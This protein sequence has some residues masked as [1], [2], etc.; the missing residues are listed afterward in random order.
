MAAAG[1]ALELDLVAHAVF[2]LVE[3]FRELRKFRRFFRRLVDLAC[4]RLPDLI[5]LVDSAGLNRRLAAAIRRRVAGRGGPFLNWRPRIVYYI[6][7][8]V[9]ASREKRAY[10]LARD[11]DLLLSIFPFERDWYARRVP[12]L[13]VEFVGHPAAE[14]CGGWGRESRTGPP[15]RVLLLPGSRVQE[16]R[17]HLPVMVEAVRMLGREHPI[18]ACM[19][20]PD[21]R[22]LALARTLV[23]VRQAE[24]WPEATTAPAH[25]QSITIT[26]CVGQLPEWLSG[27]DLAL[28][29][30]GSVTL[31]CAWFRVPAVVIYRVAWPTWVVARRLVRVA[32]VAMPNILA[33]KRVYPELLQSAATAEAIAREAFDLLH[34]QERRRQIAA[35]LDRVIESLGGS[36]AYR[37][38]AEAIVR[39]I[40]ER[41]Q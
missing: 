36:G 5:I 9:W 38:A 40:E 24:D 25:D 26:A 10:Q 8:Q 33:G 18:S 12:E 13:R 29:K 23:P 31:E 4:T 1:V 3:V 14:R 30:S 6:S 20:L 15:S 27:A 17:R 22:L 39:L 34:N 2:G 35:D 11:V 19:T 7:P 37:R 32:H 16:V 21:A 41:T 28:A